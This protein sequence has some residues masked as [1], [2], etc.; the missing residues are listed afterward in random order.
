MSCVCKARIRT[1]APPKNRIQRY[2]RATASA[3]HDLFYQ[4]FDVWR[5]HQT[6][7]AGSDLDDA[8]FALHFDALRRV[9]P[10]RLEYERF[11]VQQKDTGV[12]VEVLQQPGFRSGA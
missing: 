12:P 5:D 10:D 9:Y 1:R 3:W 4:H 7:T 6:F 11:I 2:L 8:T